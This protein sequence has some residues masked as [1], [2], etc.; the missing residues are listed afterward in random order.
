MKCPHCTTDFHE[1]W[2]A[3]RFRREDVVRK[4]I[5]EFIVRFRGMEV[6]WNYRTTICSKCKDVIIEIAP[7]TTD[8][9]SQ[10]QDWQMV[11]PIGVSRGPISPEVPAEI[12]EDY[13]EACNVLPVSPKASAALS[14]RCL[15]NILHREGYSTG[16]LFAEINL[17]LNEADPRRLF[18]KDF[19]CQF[20]L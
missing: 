5:G 7:I 11:Y 12:A 20:M 17:L 13:R 14:R 4:T 3:V 10:L 18:L 1:N 16:N 8:G 15:Q 2:T 6:F 19:V 9:H